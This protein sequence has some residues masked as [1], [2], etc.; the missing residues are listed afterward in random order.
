MSLCQSSVPHDLQKSYYVDLVLK[1]CFFII[2]INVENI[3]AA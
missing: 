1:K 3:C 2:I